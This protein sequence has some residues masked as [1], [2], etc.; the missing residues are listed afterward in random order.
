[1]AC[2]ALFLQLQPRG[3]IILV[4]A[5]NTYTPQCG[6][7]LL[8]G[9]VCHRPRPVW[10]DLTGFPHPDAVVLPGIAFPSDSCGM[11]LPVAPASISPGD[12]FVALGIVSAGFS[13]GRDV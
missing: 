7:V 13:G 6:S 1:M 4:S 3:Y 2:S 12:W 5:Q 11:G 10:A 8:I 9:R